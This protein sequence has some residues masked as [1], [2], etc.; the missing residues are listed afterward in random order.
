MINFL[1]T[2]TDAMFVFAMPLALALLSLLSDSV[3]Y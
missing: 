3:F 2:G 1:G